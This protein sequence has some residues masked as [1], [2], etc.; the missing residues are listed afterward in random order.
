MAEKP[1]I[2]SLAGTPFCL[3]SPSLRNSLRGNNL[4]PKKQG[5]RLAVSWVMPIEPEISSMF[6]SYACDSV[7]RLTIARLGMR[8]AML[9]RVPAILVGAGSGLAVAG[10]CV[11]W[12]CGC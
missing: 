6:L 3:G 11:C 7:A 12:G 1:T 10:L 2:R 8:T 9:A 5:K 4:V